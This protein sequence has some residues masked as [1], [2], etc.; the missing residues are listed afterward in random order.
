MHM[1]RE[2]AGETGASV[3][4]RADITPSISSYSLRR[5][6][7]SVVGTADFVISPGEYEERIFFRT[8]IYPDVHERGLERLLIQEILSSSIDEKYTVVPLCPLLAHHLRLHGKG[9]VGEGGAFREPLPD[10]IR[11]I[12][13]AARSEA[14]NCG[15]D[16]SV[17][18][19]QDYPATPKFPFSTE[20]DE[21]GR[22]FP[23]I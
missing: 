19:R 3:M 15:S 17:I 1:T 22:S 6:D 4:V 23:T 8:E 12:T 18:R 5:A 13:R 2:T 10:D 7:E 16:A 11:L 14:Q 9:F 21:C 20:G